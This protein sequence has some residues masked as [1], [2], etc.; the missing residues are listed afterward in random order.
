MTAAEILEK[1]RLTFAELMNPAAPSGEP[2][3][4]ATPVTAKLKDGTEVTVDKLE[5]GGIV[6]IGETPAPAGVHELEDGTKITVIDNGVIEAIE[7]PL[8]AEPPLED[9]GQK[10]SAFEGTV[11]EKFAAYDAAIAKYEERFAEQ[12]AK[13]TKASTVIEGLLGLTQLLVDNPQAPADPAATRPSGF[14]EDPDLEKQKFT[15]A[16]FQKKN[17]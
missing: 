8:P 10:F 7:T 6:M 11:N 1:V 4:M 5:P 15:S 2:A 12:E 14:T 13:I 16:L 3:A 17:K 9:F